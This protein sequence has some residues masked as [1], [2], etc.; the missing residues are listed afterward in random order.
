MAFDPL[1]AAFELGKDLIDRY[2]P[3]PEKKA[4]QIQKLEELKAQGDAEALSAHVQLMVGQ[5]NINQAEAQHKSIFVAGWRPFIGWIGGLALAWQF[6]VYPM[7]IWLWT[8]AKVKGWIPAG[9]EPPPVLD[10]GAL[11]SIVT[12]MLG[13]GAMRSMDKKNGVQTDSIKQP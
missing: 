11:F 13:I 12:G 2:F 9:I 8:L 1:T 6:I 5:M 3:D 7:L 10:T 4:E